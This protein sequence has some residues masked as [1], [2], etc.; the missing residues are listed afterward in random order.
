MK[1]GTKEKVHE[2]A[3]SLCVSVLRKCR[4]KKIVRLGDTRATKMTL[5]VECKNT[6]FVGGE[7]KSANKLLLKYFQ[8]FRKIAE[9][10]Y[11]VAISVRLSV[12][13]HGTTRLPLDGFS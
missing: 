6:K 10:D 7:C 8:C 3:L 11:S 4:Y 1:L 12:H 9:S 5:A 13:P 2:A